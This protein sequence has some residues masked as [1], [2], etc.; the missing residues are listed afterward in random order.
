MRYL[1]L[2]YVDP[3]AL[4]SMTDDE[5]KALDRDCRA[6]TEALRSSRHFI[7]A[8]ALQPVDRAVTIRLRDG[9]M[10]S[11]DG[12]FAETKEHLGGFILI[13]AADMEEAMRIAAG[14][15]AGKLSS[16]EVRA[17]RDIRDADA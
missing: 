10:S 16:I 8:E 3:R 17:I 15:S 5:R 9:K 1:C 4:Q 13:D 6:Y 2:G 7:H 12:P 14:A 11:T